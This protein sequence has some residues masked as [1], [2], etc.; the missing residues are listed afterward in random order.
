MIPSHFSSL[1]LKPL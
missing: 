1:S